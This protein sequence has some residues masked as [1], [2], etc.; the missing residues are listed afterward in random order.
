MVVKR[1]IKLPNLFI[2]KIIQTFVYPVDTLLLTLSVYTTCRSDLIP[3]SPAVTTTTLKPGN[4]TTVLNS[5]SISGSSKP[6]LA[7]KYPL[8]NQTSSDGAPSPA[9][10]DVMMTPA[11]VDD[12]FAQALGPQWNK[13][14]S[15]NNMQPQQC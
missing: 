9:H 10:S 13:L 1:T 8:K 14:K 11:S 15:H 7:P 4:M 12:H 5:T 3:T 6:P 2:I